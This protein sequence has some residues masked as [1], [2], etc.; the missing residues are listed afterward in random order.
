[1]VK[2]TR[3]A[4]ITLRLAYSK[5]IDEDIVRISAVEFFL[6][7]HET[8]L[9]SYFLLTTVAF[10]KPMPVF[11]SKDSNISMS[12]AKTLMFLSPMCL[13]GILITPDSSEEEH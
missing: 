6:K 3:K 11:V 9:L 8:E 5:I 10:T 4:I 13:T 7:L 2:V 12:V 1:M